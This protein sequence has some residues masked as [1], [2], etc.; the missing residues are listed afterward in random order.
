MYEHA[1]GSI[2]TASTKLPLHRFFPC[3]Y[4]NTQHSFGHGSFLPYVEVIL[5]H[6]NLYIF[7]PLVER[8]LYFPLPSIFITILRVIFLFSLGYVDFRNALK[9]FYLSKRYK[10]KTWILKADDR[11]RPQTAINTASKCYWK[12]LREGILRFNHLCTFKT[13]FIPILIFD[14]NLITKKK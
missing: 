10:K 14:G 3:L 2:Y 12:E 8:T 1:L 4:L 13:L 11:L 5:E 7:S 6:Y 9:C